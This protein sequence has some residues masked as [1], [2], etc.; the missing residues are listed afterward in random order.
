MKTRAFTWMIAIALSGACMGQQTEEEKRFEEAYTRSEQRTIAAYPDTTN[1]QSAIIKRMIELDEQ[2]R[3]QGD[4][5][6]H[7]PDKPMILAELAAKDLGIKAVESQLN[8]NSEPKEPVASDRNVIPELNGYFSVTIRSVEPDGLRIMHESGAAKIPIEQL[9]EEQRVKHGLTMDGARLYRKQVAANTSAYYARQRQLEAERAQVRAEEKQLEDERAA[10]LQQA[11]NRPVI[12]KRYVQ[13]AAFQEANKAAIAEEIRYM[14]GD[15]AAE[16]FL[17]GQNVKQGEAGAGVENELP[18][19]RAIEGGKY[20]RRGDR[21]TV[22]GDSSGGYQI[23]GNK[24]YSLSG[25]PTHT[26]SGGMWMPLISG[27]EQIH[28]P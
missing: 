28:D 3:E 24:L 7:S 9:T 2:M 11:S 27:H 21:I 22:N 17:R 13:N 19:T 5:R 6:Y 15:E 1:P 20:F 12:W 16:R 10:Q 26:R 25:T 14:D 23:K 18:R 8:P 4:Q